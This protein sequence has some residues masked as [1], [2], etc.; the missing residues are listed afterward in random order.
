MTEARQAL[1]RKGEAAARRYL[2]RNGVRILTANY[3]CAAGEIDLIGK[4][5]DAIL[6][7]EVK[8]RTSEAFGPPHLAVHQRKQRQIVRAAQW[9]LSER[10]MPEVACRFD[11]LAVTF[12]N[13][14]D[15]PRIQWVR[16]A[17]PAEGVR[18]W[19]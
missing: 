7:I 2:E 11:V 1:G 13:D 6:F 4:E 15:I 14:E 5:R 16:D 18:V 17:F 3:A 19:S 8:T 9:F 10:R 12:L